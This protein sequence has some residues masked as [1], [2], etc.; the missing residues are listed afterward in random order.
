MEEA[1]EEK[2]TLVRMYVDFVLNARAYTQS[3][4]MMTIRF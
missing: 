1:E 4:M 3:K 2:K